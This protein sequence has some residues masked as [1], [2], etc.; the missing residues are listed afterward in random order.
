MPE[1]GEGLPKSHNKSTRGLLGHWDACPECGS[2][3]PTIVDLGH[4]FGCYWTPPATVHI[5]GAEMSI[6]NV[7]RQRC[8]WCGIL[9]IESGTAEAR[10]LAAVACGRMVSVELREGVKV[11]TVLPQADTLP[12]GCC[13]YTDKGGD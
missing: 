13:V 8:A 2:T 3:R 1:P 9:L 12:E 5:A 11:L 7:T 10:E 6:G 4:R